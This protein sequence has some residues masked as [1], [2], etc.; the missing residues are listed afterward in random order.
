[1]EALAPLCS[2]SL[3]LLL[4]LLL[5]GAPTAAQESPPPPRQQQQQQQNQQQ[6]QQQ[7]QWPQR[8][9]PSPALVTGLFKALNLSLPELSSVAKA[10]DRG[11]TEAAC[12]LL[13]AYY[14]DSQTGGPLR[15]SSTPPPSAGSVGGD[16]DAALHD[17]YSF[18]GEVSK[19]PRN[20]TCAGMG[21]GL[22]WVFW[23]PIHDEEYFVA[24]NRHQIFVSLLDAWNLTGNP[25]YPRLFDNLT[26]DWACQYH[27]APAVIH[28]AGPAGPV[29]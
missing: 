6:Q 21:G 22:D 7:Q 18:Y 15:L 16:A 13:S 14:T 3:V 27:P 29:E 24:L 9:C 10:H 12:A 17:I 11:D 8:Q 2:I 4:S 19:V 1:M 20:V 5:L 23:G 26:A 25:A 28:G